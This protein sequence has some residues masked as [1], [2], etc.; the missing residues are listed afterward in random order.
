MSE[1]LKYLNIIVTK[2][3]RLF[4]KPKQMHCYHFPPFRLDLRAGRLLKENQPVALRAKTFALLDYL[5]ARRGQLVSKRELLTA[6]WPDVV[7]R[8][9]AL[10]VCVHELR[11]AL[12]DDRRA[13]RFIETI[14][15]RGYSFI[16]PV[17]GVTPIGLRSTVRPQL[18]GMALFS[19]VAR[20]KRGCCAGPGTE[21]STPRQTVFVTGEPGVGKTT[22]VDR[23]LASIEGS[24]TTIVGGA[25]ASRCLTRVRPTFRSWMRLAV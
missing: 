14:S 10:T 9:A 20:S 15:R 18:C 11:G 24:T 16:A 23:F 25:N 21:P 4:V 7:V 8:E 6:L 13:P 5:V 19:L 12:G 2:L 22:L 3:T 1:T 17:S